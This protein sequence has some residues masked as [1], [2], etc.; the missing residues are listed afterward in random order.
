[1]MTSWNETKRIEEYLMGTSDPAEALIFDAQLLLNDELAAKVAAQQKV[2]ETI[3][4][5]GRKELK[6]EIEAVHQ[7]LF[8]DPN[9]LSFRQKIMKLF[10]NP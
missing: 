4:Q 3:K 2:Y 9:Y 6:I 1:M 7:K 5:Y 8:T 10:K